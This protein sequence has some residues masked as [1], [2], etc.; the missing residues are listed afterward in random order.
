MSHRFRAAVVCALVAWWS[1]AAVAQRAD[2]LLFTDPAKRFSVEFPKEWKWMIV[3]GSTEALVTFVQPKSEAA[4]VVE[5][6]RLKQKLGKDEITDVFVQ[7]E[8]TSLKDN[9]P[10]ASGISGK[11]MDHNGRRAVVLEYSRPGIGEPERVRQY[12]Y[13]V[14]ESLYRVTCMALNSA[15]KKYEPTFAVI[16]DSLK[17]AAELEA[18]PKS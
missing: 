7:I 2:Y 5:R 11:L 4:V 18:K 8:T 17:S 16:A 15:F 9:Q 1:H 13:P 12:S 3:A 6:F 10:R 14:N